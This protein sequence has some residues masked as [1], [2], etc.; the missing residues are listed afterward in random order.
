MPCLSSQLGQLLAATCKELPGPKESRRT[1]KDL[2]DVVVQ[3]CSVSGQHKRSSDG[4]LSLIKQRECTL[5]IMY[6]CDR[7]GGGEHWWHP[8]LV[9]VW[10]TGLLGIM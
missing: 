2:W 10:T 7:G 3:M 4:R 5:G 1:A 6:R 8:V 9:W